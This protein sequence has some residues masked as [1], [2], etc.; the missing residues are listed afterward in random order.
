MA[1]LH[2]E[3]FKMD[4]RSLCLLRQALPLVTVVVG[5]QTS[6][7]DV[8]VVTT[9]EDADEPRRLDFSLSS[10]GSSLSPGL[11][12]WANY[13]KGVI[14]HYRGKQIG[15]DCILILTLFVKLGRCFNHHYLWVSP[16]SA[17]PVPGFRAVIASSVPL[18]G[19]LSSS[20]SL[21]VAFYTFLQQ[22][23]PGQSL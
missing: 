6:G 22:L 14:H 9:N 13:V 5:S 11:P 20:A 10:D 3:L 17:P 19:G 2:A 23:K 4:F 18:G 15:F 16:A 7:Q 1:H 12:S 8:T 21:E